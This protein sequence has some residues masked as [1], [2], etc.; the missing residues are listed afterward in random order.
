MTKEFAK[1]QVASDA[2]ETLGFIHESVQY[3]DAIHLAVEPVRA[4]HV[5]SP[6]DHIGI[7]DGKAVSHR[8]VKNRDVKLL[9]VVDPFLEDNVEM[10]EPFWLVVY[11]R[12]ITSLRHV[13][14]HP[15]FSEGVDIMFP[16][17]DG[18]D[19]VALGIPVVADMTPKQLAYQW[20]EDYANEISGSY[21]DYYSD[22]T[23]YA[24]ITA[25]ELIDTAKT[26]LKEGSWGDYIVYGGKFEGESLNPKFWDHLAI[27]LEQDIPE[28]R[29]RS[30]F[31]CSC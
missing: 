27:Y 26:H 16:N 17:V 21:H 8:Y 24:D 29:R 4:G 28:D 22:T 5:L 25:E 15:D 30:F 20:I 19:N 23:E 13:W 2:L 3:R 6:G 18:K 1:H 12:Q 14:S 7:K 10:D 9:G 11:P 31:S